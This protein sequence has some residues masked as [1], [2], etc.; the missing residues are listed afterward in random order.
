MLRW[1]SIKLSELSDENLSNFLNFQMKIYQTFWTELFP[2]VYL[3]V[4]RTREQVLEEQLIFGDPA[5]RFVSHLIIFNHIWSY[6]IIFD[7]TIPNSI[8]FQLGQLWLIRRMGWH[9]LNLLNQTAPISISR[10]VAVIKWMRFVPSSIISA[11]YFIIY[12]QMN[13]HSIYCTCNMMFIQIEIDSEW[14]IYRCIISRKGLT[15]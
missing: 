5:M 13:V 12:R 6:F 1:K 2:I 3:L 11:E 8:S 10:V 14:Y 9:K 7:M 4:S 15:V